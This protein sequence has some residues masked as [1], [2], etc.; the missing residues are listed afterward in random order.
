MIDQS[1]KPFRVLHV[2]S[3]MDR[4][5]QETLI[6]NLYR[7]IN[8]DK[9]Q[10]DFLCTLAKKGDFDDEIFSLGGRIYHLPANKYLKFK[11]FS[12]LE[13]IF[14]LAQFLKMHTE[15]K[16]VHFHNYHAFST[17]VE[18]LGAKIAKIPNIIVHSHNTSAPNGKIHKLVRPVLNL[19][20]F[21]RLACSYDAGIWMY[22]HKKTFE[23]LKNG[24]HVEDFIFSQ[25]IRNKLRK[26]LGLEDKKIILHIGRF[27]YQKN[28]RFLIDVFSIIHK[29]EPSSHLLLVGRGELENK[30]KELVNRYDLS[31]SISF[32]G[33][34]D[35]IPALFN[36]ADLFLFPS[37]FEG[38]SVVL[39]EAQ[40][41]GINILTTTN[42]AKETIYADN[43]FQLDTKINK[44]I[45]AE[46]AIEILNKEEH[47][48]NIKQATN[49]GFDIKAFLIN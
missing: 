8:R 30:I 39:V 14:R 6:M 5:G 11:H 41:N 4:A 26:E 46:K 47:I 15:F 44:Q 31:D 25:E 32:L 7:N 2:V 19:F 22:G 3:I 16:T 43:V 20:K 42:L 21:K 40:A 12:N 36:A 13:T 49:S 9:I 38:L 23:V 1:N 24:I 45:W 10:F 33:I 28:H 37:I 35:D 34:R 48:P 27:N 18:I 17:L 29:I